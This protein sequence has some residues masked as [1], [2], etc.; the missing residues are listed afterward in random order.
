[1][2]ESNV[3]TRDAGGKKAMLPWCKCIFNQIEANLA[4]IQPKNHQNVQ[5]TPFSQKAPGFN[6][7]RCGENNI[8]KLKITSFNL[9]GK[10]IVTSIRKK[11]LKCKTSKGKRGQVQTPYFTW[12]ESNANEK[13]TFVLPH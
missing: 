12:A 1:M 13:K 6:G 5:E 10:F 3:A 4:E 11:L 8:S 7:L 2:P 9:F